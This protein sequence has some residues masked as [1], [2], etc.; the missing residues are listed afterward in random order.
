MSIGN[1]K[2]FRTRERKRAPTA[3]LER[4]RRVLQGKRYEKEK[5]KALF[6]RLPVVG[7]AAGLLRAAVFFRVA[8][9]VFAGAS[10]DVA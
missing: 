8:V 7:S 6:D 1:T 9:T 3:V 10:G 4:M 2:K 5:G